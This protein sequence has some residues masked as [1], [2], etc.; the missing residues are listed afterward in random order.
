[1][2]H[3]DDMTE[4]REGVRDWVEVPNSQSLTIYTLGYR[5]RDDFDD[6]WTE[7]FNEIKHAGSVDLSAVPE[8]V[9]RITRVLGEA[10]TSLMKDLT[11][12]PQDT[13]FISAIPSSAAEATDTDVVAYLARMTAAKIGAWYLPRALTK[14]PYESMHRLGLNRE[15]R[16]L[17]Q[18]SA[19]YRF[20]TIKQRYVLVFDDV[21][22]TGSTMEAIACAVQSVNAKVKVLGIA[23][24][25]ATNVGFSDYF[26]EIANSKA[27]IKKWV[28]FTYPDGSTRNSTET[29][30]CKEYKTPGDELEVLK[31]FELI[32]NRTKLSND[33][34]PQLWE[35]LWNGTA[36]QKPSKV[37]NLKASHFKWNKVCVSWSP[38]DGFIRGSSVMYEVQGWFR[39]EHSQQSKIDF[40]KESSEYLVYDYVR[41]LGDRSYRVRAVNDIGQGPWSYVSVKGKDQATSLCNQLNVAAR[42]QVEG[43]DANSGCIGLAWDTG[44]PS[45][46]KYCLERISEGTTSRLDTDSSRASLKLP[47]VY[48]SNHCF[49][50]M[51]GYMDVWSYCS[52]SVEVVLAVGDCSQ[53][54]LLPLEMLPGGM[55]ELCTKDTVQRA[56]DLWNLVEILKEMKARLTCE[57]VDVDSGG[58]KVTWGSLPG[59]VPFPQS[60]TGPG[61]SSRERV[62]RTGIFAVRD[63]PS[64]YKRQ[65]RPLLL[66]ELEFSLDVADEDPWQ[67]VM[68]RYRAGMIV[69]G[70]VQELRYNGALVELEPHVNGVIHVSEFRKIGGTEYVWDVVSKG[71]DVRVEIL[72]I[73]LVGRRMSL[74]FRGKDH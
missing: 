60:L 17:V 37:L 19:N 5:F 18:Q 3:G 31:E 1:M 56:T 12:P 65:H 45:S 50:L 66:S 8:V 25:K 48:G 13:A 51:A 43:W 68:G 53:K 35:D 26:F 74:G 52:G 39:A 72:S 38:P 55:I 21:T 32:Y 14:Q 11:I 63:V 34:I 24:A 2:V 47:L 73:D 10:V 44:L 49:R 42:L 61:Q 4:V 46:V 30:I 15:Q 29:I 70:I 41:Y 59:Y 9:T 64:R 62:G 22:T 71:D 58:L 40:R 6:T 69:V 54:G 67:T 27:C 7:R 57:I 33:H 28:H 23:L 20:G 16:H 36:I